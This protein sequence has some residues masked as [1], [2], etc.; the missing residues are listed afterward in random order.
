MTVKSKINRFFKLL[1]EHEDAG[2]DDT[3]PR[4][5]FLDLLERS[6]QGKD[7]DK[8]SF[9]NDHWYLYEGNEEIAQELTAKYEQLHY[10]IQDALHSEI[11][12]AAHYYGIDY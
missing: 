9:N 1:Q 10:D 5:L 4:T 3:E 11:V 8:D 7:F 12:E 6:F 2:A